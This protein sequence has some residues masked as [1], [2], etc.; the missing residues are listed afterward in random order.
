[1]SDKIDWREVRKKLLRNA[2]INEGYAGP[3]RSPEEAVPFKQ[4][5]AVH[6]EAADAIKAA[7]CDGVRKGYREP[8]HG[9]IIADEIQSGKLEL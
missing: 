5:A 4:R 6:R 8:V 9:L 1:V 2:E 7:F 3:H